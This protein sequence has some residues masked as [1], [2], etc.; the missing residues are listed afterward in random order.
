MCHRILKFGLKWLIIFF[1]VSLIA[2]L[3][4]RL[5]PGNPAES[6]LQ[7]YQLASTPENVAVIEKAWGLDKP[8]YQQYFIWV[9]NFIRGDWG[10]S[11]STRLDI[12]EEILKRLPASLNIGLGGLALSSMMAFLLGYGAAVKDKGVCD[13]LSRFLSLFSLS[14]PSFV[15]TVIVVYFLGVKFGIVKFFTGDGKACMMIAVCMMALYL[16]GPSARV[17]KVHFKEQ[18]ASSHVVFAISRGFSMNYVLLR[19]TWKPVVC[20]LISVTISK[21]PTAFGGSSILEY[22]LGIQGIS[23]FLVSSMHATD[24][25]VLQS[26]IMVVVTC[27]FLSHVVLNLILDALGVKNR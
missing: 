26:Y 23:Y 14:V 7:A 10:R 13:R 4:P 5:M 24:Y 20:G 15:L 17:V 2:F 1:F 27:V 12:R 22:A 9:F 8:L 6:M 25:Y 11:L 3:C 16:V 18:M 19:H 21:I